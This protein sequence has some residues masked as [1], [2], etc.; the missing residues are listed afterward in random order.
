MVTKEEKIALIKKI[1]QEHDISAYEIG[2]N[3]SI[4]ASSAH[5]I[6]NGEQENPRTNT[7]NII[8]EFLEQKIAG[9]EGNYAL[10]NGAG[11]E[12]P[13]AQHGSFNKLNI[14]DKLNELYRMQQQSNIKI[15]MIANAL[16]NLMVDSEAFKV[17]LK[18]KKN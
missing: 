4:S 3:T 8:L 13:V 12:T 11:K 18:K 6:L 1:S 7:L 10:H 9:T 15:E 16:S 14:E 2:Q 5:K 17:V